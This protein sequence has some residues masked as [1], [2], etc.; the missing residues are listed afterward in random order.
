MRWNSEFSPR[1]SA[2]SALR[3]VA[4][5]PARSE[6]FE[7]A[8]DVQ[9]LVHVGARQRRHGQPRLLRTR[10]AD[11]EPFLLQ[12]LQRLAHRRAAHAES[13]RDLRLHDAAARREETL[14]DQVAQALIHLV[15]SRAVRRPGGEIVIG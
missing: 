11:D 14:D 7:L 4:S 5:S 15:R 8:D 12:P 1:R 10:S 3:S 13:S 2:T 6:P 9:Q